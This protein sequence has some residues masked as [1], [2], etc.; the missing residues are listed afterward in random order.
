MFPPNGDASVT[1]G[2][3]VPYGTRAETVVGSIHPPRVV[4]SQPPR[5]VP[6]HRAGTM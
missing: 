4:R 6:A 1:D 2:Q 5:R 3:C